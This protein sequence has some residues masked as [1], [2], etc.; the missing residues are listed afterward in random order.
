MRS[1]EYSNV[2]KFSSILVKINIE[3]NQT[4]YSDLEFPKVINNT[5][6]G[7]R[8]EALDFLNAMLFLIH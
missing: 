4:G 5:S 1:K 6:Y 2:Y 8:T 3:E 7:D